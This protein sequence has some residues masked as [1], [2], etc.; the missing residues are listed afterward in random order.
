MK[1]ANQ[2]T[3]PATAAAETTKKRPSLRTHVRAGEV[4]AVASAIR[5]SMA[6]GMGT[7]MNFSGFDPGGSVS[8]GMA[9]AAY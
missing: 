1:N 8:A 6:S 9:N 4:G 5:S 3:T 2:N 7:G